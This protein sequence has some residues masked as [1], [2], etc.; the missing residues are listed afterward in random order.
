MKSDDIFCKI[1]AGEIP[2]YKVYEDDDFFAFLD[3]NPINLGHTLLIPKEHY[4]YVFDMPEKLYSDI[5]IKAKKL[6][7]AIQRATTLKRVG[8]A[9]EGFS[10]PHVHIHLV[11]IN[12]VAELDPH[13]QK[14][15]SPEDLAAMARKIITEIAAS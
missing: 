4:E 7:P 2:S 5:W 1:V 12:K 10:V 14:P 3:I 15:A 6:A 9:V 11:P 8:I 13:A